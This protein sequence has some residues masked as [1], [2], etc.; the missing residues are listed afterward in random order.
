MYLFPGY[1]NH[2]P[3]LVFGFCVLLIEGFFFLQKIRIG[4]GALLSGARHISDGM[5]QAAAE[6]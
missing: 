3:F 6:W 4:L 5:L 1:G 2:S